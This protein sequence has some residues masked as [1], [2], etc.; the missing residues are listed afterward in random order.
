MFR[1]ITHVPYI[2]VVARVS[3]NCKLSQETLRSTGVRVG[4]GAQSAWYP[5]NSVIGGP[6]PPGPP[7]SAAYASL[8][9]KTIKSY[10]VT[11]NLLRNFNKVIIDNIWTVGE[12]IF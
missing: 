7:G 12:H 2:F 4:G 3:E 1:N 11:I 8:T 9:S 5:P 6:V 10:A